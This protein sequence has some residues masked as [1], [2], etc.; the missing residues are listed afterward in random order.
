M[1][2][3]KWAEKIRACCREA[4]TYKP[5]FDDAVE[6]LAGILE[7]R[8]KAAKEPLFD[9]DGKVTSGA[10][11]VNELNRD[12][13]AYWRDL[14][15]TPSGLKKINEAAVQKKEP[16]DPLAAALGKLVAMDGRG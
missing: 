2:K 1:T 14:G 12:A 6:T 13:L 11:L 4:G 10:K 3:R 15:L 8:D 9:G 5:C 7:R 16:D